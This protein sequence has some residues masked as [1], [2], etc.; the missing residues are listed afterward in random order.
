MVRDAPPE[1]PRDAALLV[2]LK[3]VDIAGRSGFVLV[4]TYALPIAQA[5]QFGL[6]VT[7]TTLFAFVSG[8]ERHLDIQR[9]VAGEDRRVVERAVSRAVRF[10]AFNWLATLPIYLLIVVLWSGT[11]WAQ[12]APMLIVVIGEHLATQTYNLSVMSR[13]YF[14]LIALVAV[15]N[16]TLFGFIAHRALLTEQGLDVG[17]ALNAWACASA[18][19]VA[20]AAIIWVRL[21]QP[22]PERP[23]FDFRSDLFSQHRASLTHFVIGVVAVL[24]LQYDRLAVTALLGLEGG[25]RYFRHAIL[26]SLAYQAFNVA[27]FTR[28]S[29]G[30]FVLARQQPVRAVQLRLMREYRW[31][32]AGAAALLIFAWSADALTG[33]VYSDQF[34]V[35]LGI[36]SLMMLGF[37]VRAAADFQGLILNARHQE[38]RLLR[39]QGAAFAVGAVAVGLLTWRFG[40][41]GA[42]AANVLGSAL[43]LFLNHRAV[44]TLK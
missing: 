21:R 5:G 24:M 32:L 27:C 38:G 26:A 3:V 37:V 43:Y 23:R 30:I 6:I 22:D 10:F 33:S 1:A 35:S 40:L 17:F 9:R 28:I 34:H 36:M 18:L 4:A 13:R 8:F 12:A 44:R 11:G 29:P 20:G 39:Q 16:A 19:G 15:K 31:V 41:V 42:V 25:G 14:P 2:G 7:L